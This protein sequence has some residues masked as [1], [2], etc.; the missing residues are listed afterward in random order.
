MEG[1]SYAWHYFTI[2][3]S[4]KFNK[5]AENVDVNEDTDDGKRTLITCGK[6]VLMWWIIKLICGN[7]NKY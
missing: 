4:H 6:I 3:A 1:S 7:E 5:T 2:P